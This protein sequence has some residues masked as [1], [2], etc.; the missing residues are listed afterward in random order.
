MVWTIEAER[1]FEALKQSMATTPILALPDFS[2]EFMVECDASDI[3]IGVVLSQVGHPITFLSKTLAKRHM[4]L[5][6]YNKE[7]L[8][9][10]FAVQHWRPYLLGRHF[11]IFTNHRT[12]QYF[13]GQRITTLAQQK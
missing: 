6:V 2:K 8:V 5:L 7:M 3:G 11:K 1:A 9:V 10:V 12:I 4:A 13:L